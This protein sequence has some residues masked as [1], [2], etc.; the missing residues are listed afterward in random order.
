VTKKIEFT[1]GA[2]LS[3][4][5]QQTIQRWAEG[6]EVTKQGWSLQE[7]IAALETSKL[8]LFQS[9]AKHG[10]KEIER[11]FRQRFEGIK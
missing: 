7:I 8:A 3:V 5:I 6:R 1:K 2:D 9:W 10:S 4:M 11:E